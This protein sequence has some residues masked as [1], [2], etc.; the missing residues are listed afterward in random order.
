MAEWA[1]ELEALQLLSEFQAN[2]QLRGLSNGLLDQLYCQ[3]ME[4]R[5]LAFFHHCLALSKA[6]IA[7]YDQISDDNESAFILLGD[8]RNKCRHYAIFIRL[9]A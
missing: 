9:H 4:K 2:F 1:D 7:E 6:L 3:A 5:D 8:L